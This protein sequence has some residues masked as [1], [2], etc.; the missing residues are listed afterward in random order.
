MEIRINGIPASEGI[1]IGPVKKLERQAIETPVRAISAEEIEPEQLRFRAAVQA[2]VA[3][4]EAMI[5]VCPGGERADILEA[6]LTILQDPYLEQLTLERIAGGQNAECALQTAADEISAQFAALD[7]E[8]LRERAADMRDECARIMRRLSGA[9]EESL[10]AAAQPVILIA[11]DLTPSDTAAMDLEKVLGFATGLGGKT[12]HTAIIARGVGLPAV[13]GAGNSLFDAA[14]E[15]DTV[16][17]DGMNG[18]VILRPDESTLQEY[19]KRQRA[20]MCELRE[21]AALR[22]L[23]AITADGRR[24]ELF[25]NIGSEK[26]ANVAAANG[27]EGIGLFRSEFLYMEAA[28]WPGEEA[29]YA[30]YRYVA[31]AMQGQPV[32]VRTLDIGGDKALPYHIFS[33]EE[34]PFLG[35]RA[36][37]FCLS[38]PAIFKTQL[39]AILRASAHGQLRIMLPMVISAEEIMASRVLL[40]QCMEELTQEHIS[41]DSDIQLGIMIETPASVLQAERFAK[42]VDFLS[43]GTNDLTQYLLA[44]DRGNENIQHLYNPFHPAVLGAIKRVI[45]AAHTA[46]IPAGMCGELAS[47]PKAVQILLGMGLDEFSVSPSAIPRLKKAIRE[48]SQTAAQRLVNT[49][50]SLEYAQD[51]QRCLG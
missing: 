49:V 5:T 36:L 11:H 1:A 50:L 38:E 33:H 44:V 37:R 47:D 35:H 6:H 14:T 24:V 51:I 28:N 18:L 45:D 12:S 2:C 3:Q 48:T 41:Y 40:Q 10:A 26:E 29:Q 46:G 39:R 8:C 25:A 30:S 20:Y 16:I 13:V 21:L 17:V 15:G 43:I 42:L 19:S 22:D 7:D 27:A 31:K 4:L 9:G 32:I 23:P 34:N